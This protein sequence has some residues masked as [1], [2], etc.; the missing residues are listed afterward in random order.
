MR[1]NLSFSTKKT[2]LLK[3]IQF[4]IYQQNCLNIRGPNVIHTT[5]KISYCQKNKE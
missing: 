1:Q 2:K 3:N 4:V 5:R